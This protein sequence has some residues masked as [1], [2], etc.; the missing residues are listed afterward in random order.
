MVDRRG[1]QYLSPCALYP[2][3]V[4]IAGRM[5]WYRP[6][7]GGCHREGLIGMQ[8]H[9]GVSFL[10]PLFQYCFIMVTT[11]MAGQSNKGIAHLPNVLG[12][13][14]VGIRVLNAGIRSLLFAS[15]FEA[16]RS[17]FLTIFFSFRLS[18]SYFCGLVPS[19]VRA[20]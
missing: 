19:V 15:F 18:Q 7:L 9:G 20:V 6:A 8:D 10:K 12:L 11:P 2:I 17:L 14:L 5:P 13:R 4:I 1:D 3:G 16:G